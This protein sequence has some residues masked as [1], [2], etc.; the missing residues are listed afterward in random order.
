MTSISG[1][2]ADSM[3]NMMNL[4]AAKIA[5]MTLM[6]DLAPVVD[7]ITPLMMDI[8]SLM[9]ADDPFGVESALVS[10]FFTVNDTQIDIESPFVSTFCVT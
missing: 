6:D 9:M 7:S 2:K 5:Q 4:E 1:L 3:Q 8:D 10:D